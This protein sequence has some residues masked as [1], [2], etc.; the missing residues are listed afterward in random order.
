MVNLAV[1]AHLS[2]A[3]LI[4]SLALG[5]G[6][7]RADDPP[8]GEPGE[9]SAGESQAN[10]GAVRLAEVEIRLEEPGSYTT[11]LEAGGATWR[12]PAPI[13]E[14][15]PCIL[16]DVPSGFARVVLENTEDEEHRVRTPIILR[17]HTEAV[18][19]E[20]GITIDGATGYLLVGLG[21]V[22]AGPGVYLSIAAD[23]DQSDRNCRI[24]PLLGG[25]FITIGAGLSLLGLYLLTFGNPYELYA[26]DARR[27]HRPAV[28]PSP[29][30]EIDD[31]V[32]NPAQTP[33]T[34]TGATP[35]GG[36]PPAPSGDDNLGPANTGQSTESGDEPPPPGPSSRG[37]AGG[38]G[39]NAAGLGLTLVF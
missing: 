29:T 4:A 17:E 15:E 38:V 33:A 25:T 16:R 37:P 5:P 1:V 8:A 30:L 22:F 21:L 3:V 27:E 24:T 28:S 7:A 35:A 13:R 9:P 14:G 10:P 31:P 34:D 26:G 11:S 12:C 19:V 23:C 39:L 32:G 36:A 6:R 20:E 2:A 18:V